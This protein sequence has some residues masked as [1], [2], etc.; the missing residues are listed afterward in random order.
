[1]GSADGGGAGPPVC[2]NISMHV[3][4]RFGGLAASLPRFCEA[5][6]QTGRFTSRL[7]AFCEKD[8]VPSARAAEMVRCFP[9]GRM[10]WAMDFRLRRELA[11]LIEESAIVHIHGLWQEHSLVAARLCRQLGRPY[12]VSAHGMIEPWALKQGRWKKRAY[13]AVAEGGVL[14]RAAGLRALTRAEGQFYRDLGLSNPV[15][16]VPNGID[17]PAGSSPGAFLE[18]FPELSGR[19]LVLFLGR[20]HAKK[21]LDILCRAWAQIAGTFPEAQLVIAGPGDGE[22]VASLTALSGELGMGS[23]VT[24][25]GMLRGELKWSALAAASLFVLPSHSE[26]FS[27]AVLEALGAGLPVVI[28]HGCHFP[29]VGEAGCGWE[30]NPQDDEVAGAVSEALSMD[31]ETL[32]ETG[33]RGRRLAEARFGWAGIGERTADMLERWMKPR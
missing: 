15:E 14:R 4:E 11:G 10:R 18:A 28:S 8:E 30:V 32:R 24:F 25:T 9:A 22:L 19:R 21:G 23:R 29:E 27:M 7:A 3:D 26:G 17:L 2:L 5:V 20:L 33:R 1:M 16:V 31:A 12:V 13:L 6:T